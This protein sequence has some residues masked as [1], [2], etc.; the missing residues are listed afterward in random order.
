M[1]K[2]VV[3]LAQGN[4]FSRS[5]EGGAIADSATRVFKVILNEPNEALDIFAAI[6]VNIGDVYSSANPIPCVSVEGRSDGDSRLVRVITAQ[7]RSRSGGDGQN[8][9]GTQQPTLRPAN[10]STST[11]LYEAPAYVW[12]AN[13]SVWT[14]IVNPVNDR[15][16]GVSK[17][18]AITTIRVTQFQAFPGTTFA[19]YCGYINQE[20]M[21][22][23]AYMTCQPKTVLF[24]GV[25]ANPAVESF[26]GVLYRGF[27]N[28][29]EFAYRANYVDGLGL[30]GWDATPI[31]EGFNIINSGLGNSAVDQDALVLELDGNKVKEPDQLAAGTS[32]KKVRA[33][34]TINS[35]EGGR[36]QN[37]ATQPVALNENGTPRSRNASP[38]VLLWRRQVQP[39]TN[40]TNLLQLRLGL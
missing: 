10:F 33:M 21:S 20:T 16:D 14:P 34:V 19:A 12:S 4:T 2:S 9:P 40:L 35:V 7:Y 26:G 29:Y 37:P 18:E 32:G 24:R 31:V 3:E 36:M 6:G 13:G 38:P 25:E 17:M 27:M 8:D 22:L 11:T 15:V 28:A 1:P 30:C 5:S 39:W 23:G